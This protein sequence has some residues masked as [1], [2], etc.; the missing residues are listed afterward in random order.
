MSEM[1]RSENIVIEGKH[2]R[3]VI[4]DIFKPAGEGHF[5][6]VIFSHGF[7]G[8]KDW[9]P[10]NLVASHFAKQGFVFVKI[11]FAFNGTTPLTPFEFSDLEA[12]GQNSLLKELDDLDVTLNWIHEN[13]NYL[14]AD[15]GNISLIG[16][17]RGAGIS[18]LKA[19]E[20]IRV[21]KVAG[22]AS[23]AGFDHHFSHEDILNWKKT[24]VH[25]V[26]NARTKQMMPLYIQI[27][28][29]FIQ[30]H[31]RYNIQEAIRSISKPVFLAHAADDD[32]I[33][34]DHIVQLN[35]INP[36]NI[37]FLQLPSGGH[38]FDAAHPFEGQVL[39]QSFQQVVDETLAFL[40]T[41]F[42]Q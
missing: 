24:G 35:E 20:D 16:H 4:A 30:N 36:L 42:K 22:W 34:I 14:S 29:D 5:P 18:I 17:S 23:V 25:F 11:N 1:R 19:F 26:E 13:S 33:P 8:F 38:T 3:P 27:Y 41:H 10:F 21:A 6:V 37:R 12:F 15:V 7:K 31:R 39:P 32:T 40:K 2:G 9:G 28:D